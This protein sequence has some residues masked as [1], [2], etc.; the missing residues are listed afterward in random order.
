MLA[1]LVAKYRKKSFQVGVEEADL[2]AVSGI[3]SFLK[4]F[5]GIGRVVLS[6]A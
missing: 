1:S 4:E 6:L 5:A 3:P 2:I